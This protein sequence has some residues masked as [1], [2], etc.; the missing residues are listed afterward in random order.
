[1][2]TRSVKKQHEALVLLGRAINNNRNAPG[3]GSSNSVQEA[4]SSEEKA[5]S[6][7]LYSGAASAARHFWIGDATAVGGVASIPIGNSRSCQ[8]WIAIN[9]T[10][11][12]RLHALPRLF[13]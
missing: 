4:L 5:Q 8:Y 11:S 1:M 3:G 13:M 7:S 2:D 6:A 9:V 10:V 12:P